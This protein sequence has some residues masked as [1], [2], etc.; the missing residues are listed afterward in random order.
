MNWKTEIT[1][2]KDGKE[3]I[4][5]YSLSNLVQNKSFT[6][7]IF[8]IL[9]GE[10]PNENETQMFDA[11]LTCAI[12]HGPGTVSA[13]TA[14]IN[15]SAKNSMHV[16]VAS[17]ILAMGE[18][19][20][21]AI[22]DAG[23]FFKENIKNANIVLLLTTMKEKNIRV[24]GFGHAV[25]E[26]DSRTDI[27]FEVAKTTGFF[28]EHCMFAQKV[29]KDLQMQS[30]KVLPLNIDGAMG[31]ILS[32]MKFDSRMMKGIFIIARIPGLVAQVYEEMT[33]DVG[34]R[35]VPESDIDYVGKVPQILE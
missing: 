2:I 6:E 13:Q 33:H 22:E 30:S 31:A 32:D 35:R 17:G 20:G 29:E 23:H 34:L 27:L 5:G 21:S 8:L 24:P 15:A 28:K 19:H 11:L 14:R 25:L 7:T 4:F 18:R 1:N 12:D 10:L 16:S 9:K 26:H 3:Y